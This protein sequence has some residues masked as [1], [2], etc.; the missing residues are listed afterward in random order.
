METSHNN[1]LAINY[2]YGRQ[3]TK[4]NEFELRLCIAC[5]FILQFF[6]RSVNNQ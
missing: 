5:G 1:L 3:A 4:T 2:D 6:G